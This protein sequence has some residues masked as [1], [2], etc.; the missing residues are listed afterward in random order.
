MCESHH[1]TFSAANLIRSSE[2]VLS[3]ACC[4]PHDFNQF[5]LQRLLFFPSSI[6]FISKVE[7]V[8]YVSSVDTVSPGT[9][10][11]VQVHIAKWV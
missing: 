1:L 9:V 8:T 10:F 5:P 6:A 7:H 4:S 3:L 2:P 11:Q